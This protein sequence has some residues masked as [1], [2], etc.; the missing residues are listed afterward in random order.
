MS[1]G[2]KA[3]ARQTVSPEELCRLINAELA[4]YEV[5][6][7]CQL[8]AVQE[9]LAVN[10]SGCNWEPCALQG[11]NRGSPAFLPVFAGVI[12]SFRARYNVR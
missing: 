4:Q 5:C 3:T 10:G 12:Q 9:M 8:T 7:S 6:G 1:G 11:R 2:G